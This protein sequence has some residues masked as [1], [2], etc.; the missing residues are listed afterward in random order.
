[1]NAILDQIA[2]EV[3]QL[4]PAQRAE[5]VDFLLENLESTQPDEIQ[6]LWVAEASR[7]LSEVRSGNVETISGEEV[8]AEVRHLVNR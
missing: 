6:R 2:Q 8:L 3:L 4:T 5:L 1:M 7:R